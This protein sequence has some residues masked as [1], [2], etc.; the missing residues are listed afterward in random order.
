MSLDLDAR[1]R[2]MLQE[3]GV[4]VWWPATEP[5]SDRQFAIE[6][7]VPS[8]HSEGATSQ[9]HVSD[10]SPAARPA[11]VRHGIIPVKSDPAP[12]PVGLTDL[13]LGI[14]GMDWPALAAAVA[15]CQACAM[16]QGRRAPVLAVPSQPTQCDWLVLGDPPDESQERFG[17]PFVEDAGKLLD[18]M[19][20]AVGV[21]RLQP[22]AGLALPLAGPSGRAYLSHVVKCRPA[23]SR[24]PEVQEL[25]KCANYL[26]REIELIRPKV[27]LAMGRF[28]M[29]LL[30]SETPP[31]AA[32][33]PLGKLRG[34]VYRYQGV[35]VVL[36][37][38]PSYLLRSGQDKAR[39]WADLCL[40]A[41]VAQG[42][43]LS[44]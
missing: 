38:P 21:S 14:T 20:R 43:H 13:P 4:H 44:E 27:I 1:Q 28:A 2:A 24:I 37:Y 40:A 19:L 15:Q 41:G 3:M 17:L 23:L 39:A 16:C 26:N 8:A 10:L 25:A 34:K 22:V 36:T 5:V 32:L 12:V 11:V 9:N 33:L 6:N 31:A 7:E 30:L 42:E 18:N 29:Q 35:P